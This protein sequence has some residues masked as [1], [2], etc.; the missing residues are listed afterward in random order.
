M[1]VDGGLWRNLLHDSSID[2]RESLYK[3][4]ALR[5]RKYGA[6]KNDI[7]PAWSYAHHILSIST[8]ARSYT[9]CASCFP[10]CSS[11]VSRLGCNVI[12]AYVHA[13]LRFEICPGLITRVPST[14][15]SPISYD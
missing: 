2:T 14:T 8:R 12:R 1:N 4:D 9:L 13:A 3:Y 5:A 7:T 11:S 10:C 15:Y 6:M